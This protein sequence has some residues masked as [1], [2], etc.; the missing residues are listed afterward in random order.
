MKIA[1]V[2]C[3]YVGMSNAV[4]LS[5][6]NEVIALDI[7]QSS[8]DAIN[9]K[10]STVADVDL[11][12]YL[13]NKTLNLRATNNHVEAYT[14]SDYVI[15][16]TPTDYDP[17]NN[18]FDTSS[19]ES[20]IKSIRA[21]NHKAIIVIKSTIPVGFVE[22]ARI[23]YDTDNI[24]FSPE[25]LREGKALFDNLHPSRIVVGERSE[26]GQI[27]AN[28]MLEGAI[29]KDAEVLLTNPTEAEAIKLFS[30]TYLAMRVAY[31]NELDTYA[32]IHNLDTKQIIQGVGLDPRIGSHYNN[33][34]FGYGG[35]CLPKDTKQL[36]ANYNDVPNTLI[37]AIVDS[38][39]VRKDFIAES[40]LRRNPKTVGV[41]RLTMKSNSDNFRTSS[42][43]GIM[44]R[45]KSRGIEVVV[46]EP[47]FNDELFFN[48]KAIRDIKEFKDRC[49]VIIANRMTDEISDIGHK[50]YTR[51]LFG[52]D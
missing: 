46:Y 26:R 23:S 4:L 29:D 13:D 50:V 12:Y 15:V 16:A 6:Y 48:S 7:K 27:F 14:N 52:R 35:Y 21:V 31:F 45:I 30:N 37:Q 18:F 33:P 28:L 38:N 9:N 47:M 8:V 44:K 42:I 36:L 49:D 25:F 11:Q 2:G 19:V 17:I 1:V 20:S 22:R 5:Q 24:I 41:Y 34:S 10:K 3:G 43:Q 32:E 40:I 51:D 39:R